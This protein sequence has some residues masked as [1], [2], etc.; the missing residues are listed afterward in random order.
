M[1]NGA[2]ARIPALVSAALG[3][4][5]RGRCFSQSDWALDELL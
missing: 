2:A 5:W 1:D 3:G 4:S